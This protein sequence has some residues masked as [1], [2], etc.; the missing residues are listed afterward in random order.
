[1][2]PVSTVNMIDSNKY[3]CIHILQQYLLNEKYYFD[4]SSVQSQTVSA[5]FAE[6]G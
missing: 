4:S 1:M 6:Y 5:Y 3:V 2:P